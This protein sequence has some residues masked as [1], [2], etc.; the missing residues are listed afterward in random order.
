LVAAM[1]REDLLIRQAAQLEG[2]VRW[3][4]RRPAVHA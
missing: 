1:G 3:S 4:E 2:E